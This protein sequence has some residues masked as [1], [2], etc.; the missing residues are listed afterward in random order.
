MVATFCGFLDG[1][2]NFAW[3]HALGPELSILCE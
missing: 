3:G 2:N 1:K